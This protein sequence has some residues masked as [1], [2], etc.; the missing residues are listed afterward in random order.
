MVGFAGCA[1]CVVEARAESSADAAFA[2]HG[3]LVEFAGSHGRRRAELAH[4]ASQA[5]SESIWERL[6]YARLSDY[7]R[8][9]LG[10]SAREV[11]DLAHVGERLRELPGLREALAGGSLAWTKVRLV[12]RVAKPEDESRWIDCARRLRG[13]ALEREVRRVDVRA[14]DAVVADSWRAAPRAPV[15]FVCTPEVLASWHGIRLLARRVAGRDVSAGETLEMVTAE[16]LSSIPLDRDLV[17]EPE[18]PSGESATDAPQSPFHQQRPA[19]R[20]QATDP[21]EL[22]TRLRALV[23]EEQCAEASM[24]PLL[25]LLARSHAYRAMGYPSLGSYASELLGLGARKAQMLVRIERAAAESEALGTAYREG[26]LSWVKADALVPLVRAD[27]LGRFDAGWVEWAKRVTVRRLKDDVERALILRE[28]DRARWE[29]TGGLPETDAASAAPLASGALA[30]EGLPGESDDA[31]TS[32]A[33]AGDALGGAGPARTAFA[34]DSASAQIRAL[35]SAAQETCE[36]C[37]VFLFA[38]TETRRLFWATLHTV[39][40][41]AERL[42]GRLPTPGQAF[43][44]M[45]EHARAAWET[46][47]ARG[48]EQKVF[49]RD[50]WMCAVPGCSS[51]RN[52]HAHH[53]RFRAAGGEDDPS[54]LISLCAWHHLRGV[55][56]GT[57]RISGSAPD[58]LRFALGARGGARS[59]VVYESGDRLL[60]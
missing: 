44:M 27:T 1:D 33:P 26:S 4:A 15:T 54:N 50:D 60:G 48:R 43:G 52:L 17:P 47:P 31:P 36:T 40:R 46:Q 38:P 34:G 9:R 18:L 30:D 14:V 53:V 16:V 22:D 11:E 6:G 7:A 59:L 10:L 32:E 2:A 29:R 8:E 49:E 28:I 39:R 23:R 19:Q 25:L 55:H 58:R 56:A 35:E 45:L 21:W 24:G 12:A 13:S 57:V 42:T 51:R 41:R 20:Q 5:V 3:W 37:E